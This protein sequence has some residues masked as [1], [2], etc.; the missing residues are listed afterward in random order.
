MSCFSALRILISLI[1]RLPKASF[2]APCL[3]FGGYAKVPVAANCF[4]K[5]KRNQIMLSLQ[6][7]EDLVSDRLV[8]SGNLVLPI[9]SPLPFKV[10]RYI[11]FLSI[12]ALID[13]LRA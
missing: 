4:Q 6:G 3:P 7:L 1:F 2:A 13:D 11:F 9:A 8:C 10:C 12:F 5:G